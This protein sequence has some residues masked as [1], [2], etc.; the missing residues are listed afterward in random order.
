MTEI[1]EFAR[2]V[3]DRLSSLPAPF[4][5]LVPLPLLAVAAYVVLVWALRRLL[6]WLAQQGLA[7]LVVALIAVLGIVA[8]TVEF[9][10]TQVFRVLGRRPPGTLYAAGDA[11]VVSMAAL[12]RSTRGAGRASR[13]MRRL[14]HMAMLAVAVAL[15]G[16]W[17]VGYCERRPSP[18]SCQAPVAAW[19]RLVTESWR[20]AAG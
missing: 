10:L 7:P 6:P 9:L 2:W 19:A 18:D 1:D 3:G 4:D 8:L 5:R 12:Q 11:V 20:A 16:W 14:S 17:N 13:G 15:I